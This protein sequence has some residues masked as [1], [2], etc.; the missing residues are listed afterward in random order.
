MK[1]IVLLL[2]LMGFSL[3]FTEETWAYYLEEELE[4]LEEMENEEEW[5]QLAGSDDDDVREYISTYNFIKSA[6]EKDLR[7]REEIREE[8]RK[9]EAHDYYMNVE[10]HYPR[11]QPAPNVFIHGDEYTGGNPYHG[12]DV[13][14]NNFP[15]DYVGEFF[16]K[17]GV[18]GLLD[19]LERG[20]IG[21]GDSCDL[22]D[23][24]EESP[25]SSLSCDDGIPLE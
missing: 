12:Q 18:P 22:P 13:S 24:A 16:D 17:G 23:T 4:I 6:I 3:C 25:I 10:R 14:P 20:I 5:V 7:R 21:G 9:Q 11:N 1:N 19:R 2:T 15:T 8:M